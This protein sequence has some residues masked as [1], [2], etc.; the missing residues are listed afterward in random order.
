MSRFALFPQKHWLALELL[1]NELDSPLPNLSRSHLYH[2]QHQDSGVFLVSEPALAGQ[3]FPAEI[4]DETR[5]EAVGHDVM[6]AR[7][8]PWFQ[9]LQCTLERL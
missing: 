3:T 4:W 8:H 5:K 7:D 6:S 9:A 2:C 1:L